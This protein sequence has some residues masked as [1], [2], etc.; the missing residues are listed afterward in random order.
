MERD[1]DPLPFG[2]VV[3]V[4]VVGVRGDADGLAERP[5]DDAA[6]GVRHTNSKRTRHESSY[7]STAN[8]LFGFHI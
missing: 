5:V 1:R 7:L 4:V 6:T 8:D 3:V 2:G